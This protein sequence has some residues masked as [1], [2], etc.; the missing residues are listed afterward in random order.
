[1]SSPDLLAAMPDRVL[2]DTLASIDAVI[3]H[4]AERL[5]DR[6][7]RGGRVAYP[8]IKPVDEII[9]IARYASVRRGPVL[10]EV[11]RREDEVRALVAARGD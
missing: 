7:A 3:E 4:D 5:T 8:K 11:E 1:M 2:A 6:C 9:Q 10:A